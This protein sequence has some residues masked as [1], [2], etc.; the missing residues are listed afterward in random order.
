MYTNSREEEVKLFKRLWVSQPTLLPPVQPGGAGAPAQKA[1]KG[2]C[3]WK[4]P[5]C[6]EIY[7]TICMLKEL[8]DA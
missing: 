4:C 7:R 8:P 1:K 3:D 6:G 5:G 2:D